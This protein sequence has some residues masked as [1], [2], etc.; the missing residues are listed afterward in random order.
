MA[1]VLVVDDEKAQR[2][3]IAGFLAKH[4]WEV[5]TAGGGT[6][7]IRCV[8]AN[9][10]DAVI[11]DVRMPDL[12]GR[13][14]F[15]ELHRSHPT[16]PVILMTAYGDIRNAVDAMKE[17][18]TDYLTKPLDLGELLGVLEEATGTG[19]PP[20]ER[21]EV[22]ALPPDVI[23]ESPVFRQ[24]IAEVALVA[25]SEVTCLLTGESGSG[26]EVLAE[27]IHRWS[28]RAEGPLVRVN[29]AAI[30]STLIE[31]ELFGH[32]RG[33]F[34]GA[35]EDRVGHIEAAAGGTLF[36]DEIGDLPAELQAH[37]LRAL[38]TKEFRPVGAP[39]AR[40]ADFRLVV[41]TNR[42]LEEA[43]ASGAFREDL[44]Y[45]I[46][47][48]RLEVPPLRERP[49][50]ILPLARSFLRHHD[51][52]AI[53]FSPRAMAVF[54]AYHWPGNVRELRNVVERAGILA[55]GDVILPEHLPGRI[56]EPGA[57]RDLPHLLRPLEETQKLAILEAL[58]QCRGNRTHAAK[59]LGISRRTLLNRLKAYGIGPGYGRS[60]AST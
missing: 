30:P 46:N 10:P 9:P 15:R 40:H 41:A 37:L 6:E 1:R 13:A 42:N 36:L 49:E 31:S 18:V 59:L 54:T 3:I 17:G 22:P 32:T 20:G 7:A 35:F 27:L 44:Y 5:A 19:A 52:R 24:T 4:G 26:K 33:A 57:A 58:K 43:I 56:G 8:A 47:V 51:A 16:L 53:R 12:D 23:A 2:D 39:N 55:R 29:M 14:A 34:T 45:R 25:P 60:S 38:E 28:P 21:V 48:F 11:M 50:D